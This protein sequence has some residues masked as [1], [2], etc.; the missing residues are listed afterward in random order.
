M[1]LAWHHAPVVNATQR[2][3]LLGIA[4]HDGDGGAWP[5]MATLAD[6]ACV[7]PR[8]AQRIVA[9]LERMG[10][11][12][13]DVQAGGTAE[14]AHY[15]RPNLYH[16]LLK[17]PDNCDRSRNHKLLCRE[18]GKPIPK[19]ARGTGLH[20]KCEPADPLTP[21]SPGDT[22]VARGVSPM[23]PKPS[24]EPDLGLSEETHVIARAG[25]GVDDAYGDDLP[26]ATAASHPAESRM[27]SESERQS[28]APAASAGYADATH[29][30][31]RVNMP[32]S[33][34]RAGECID[35]HALAPEL[36]VINYET[37]EVA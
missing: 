26:A 8:Q 36:Q 24:L 18:C 34:N 12:K 30:P 14:I 2:V 16:F 7:T 19:S 35:C 22:H 33:Y 11:I 10:A 13:R 9:E 25:I 6:Y 29:C 31:K 37:G 32:H 15:D 27:P 1:S 17:C 20:P 5:T 4:N 3:V 23:S 28:R 21:V